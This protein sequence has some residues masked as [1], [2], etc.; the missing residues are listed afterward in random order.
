MNPDYPPIL[1]QVYDYLKTCRFD[2]QSNCEDDGRFVSIQ[3]EKD[4]QSHYSS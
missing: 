4:L 3:K 2:L 1:S